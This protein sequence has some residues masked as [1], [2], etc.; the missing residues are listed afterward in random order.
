MGG[1]KAFGHAR[2]WIFSRLKSIKLLS[3][4]SGMAWKRIFKY[5]RSDNSLWIYDTKKMNRVVALKAFLIC[6]TFKGLLWLLPFWERSFC[7]RY[8]KRW[9]TSFARLLRNSSAAIPQRF[10]RAFSSVYRFPSAEL[11]T[12]VWPRKPS[13]TAR[14]LFRSH[15]NRIPR[16][17]ITSIL[18]PCK[19]I[20]P[21]Q[22]HR[23]RTRLAPP[24]R[25]PPSRE[26][27]RAGLE[28]RTRWLTLFAG[29]KSNRV[30]I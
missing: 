6:I 8:A 4:Y 14:D 22:Q 12:R 20:I 23:T 26:P 27:R 28:P 11:F 18:R 5:Y 7:K 30:I 10:R 21:S 9:I 17:G 25:P 24:P 16:T 13:S 19:H 3:L 1:N 15:R 2:W 29:A